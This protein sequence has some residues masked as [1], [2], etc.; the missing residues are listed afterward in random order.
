MAFGG[1]GWP[2]TRWTLCFLSDR[3]TPE[4]TFLT[5]ALYQRHRHNRPA[6]RCVCARTPALVLPCAVSGVRARARARVPFFALAIFRYPSHPLLVPKKK[7][8][9]F[10]LDCGALSWVFLTLPSPL[11]LPFRCCCVFALTHSSR[12]LCLESLTRALVKR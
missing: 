3:T 2:L 11:L 9:M 5:S 8:A 7:G 6:C 4:P 10:L 1:R 12:T